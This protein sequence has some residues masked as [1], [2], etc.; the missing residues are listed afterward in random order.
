VA[1]NISGSESLGTTDASIV[2]KS[3][4][5]YIAEDRAQAKR[6]YDRWDVGKSSGKTIPRGPGAPAKSSQDEE[7]GWYP[8]TPSY[9]EF[10]KRCG[11]SWMCLHGRRNPTSCLI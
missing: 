10:I 2:P 4:C 3:W 8:P 7:E 9:P 11:H 6:S 5:R 1:P